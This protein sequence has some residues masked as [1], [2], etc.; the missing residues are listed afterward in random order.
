MSQV[1]VST[2]G[3]QLHQQMRCSSSYY[4]ES[5]RHGVDVSMHSFIRCFSCSL[6]VSPGLRV[7][8]RLEFFCFRRL[9][10]SLPEF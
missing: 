4:H 8:V 10:S 3:I 7:F 9:F 1:E 5:S 6:G 2:T